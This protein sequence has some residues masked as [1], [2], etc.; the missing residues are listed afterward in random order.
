VQCKVA[1]GVLRGR[2]D[3]AF[4]M[5]ADAGASIQT[6]PKGL[7][8]AHCTV[9][10]MV[11]ARGVSLMGAAEVQ[12]GAHLC[13]KPMVVGRDACSTEVV[14]AQRVYM[15]A[16]NSA[17]HMEVGSAVQRLAAPRAPAAAL[18]TV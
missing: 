11:A 12:R 9:R 5:A 16:R 7:R 14:S 3:S 1:F 15:V 2:L 6:V 18:T 10:H 17:W 13:A 8:A 4:L